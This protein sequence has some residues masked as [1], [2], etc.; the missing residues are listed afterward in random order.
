MLVNQKFEQKLTKTSPRENDETSPSFIQL[1]SRDND[2][3][4][5]REKIWKDSSF[6]RSVDLT[7]H[8]LKKSGKEPRV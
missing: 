3:I 8:S 5:K 2:V 4:G 6:Y 7:N 1:E